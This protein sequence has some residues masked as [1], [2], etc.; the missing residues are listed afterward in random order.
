MILFPKKK[1]RKVDAADS[2]ILGVVEN[3][4]TKKY[5]A[6]ITV[7][8]RFRKMT[9]ILE[10]ETQSIEFVTALFEKLTEAFPNMKNILEVENQKDG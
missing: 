3:N 1:G 5:G 9:Y 8:K 6:A 2:I 4:L 10:T 7:K